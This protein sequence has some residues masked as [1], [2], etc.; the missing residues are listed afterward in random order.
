MNITIIG[1]GNIA[2]ALISCIKRTNIEKIFVL[3]N[4]EYEMNNIMVECSSEFSR[5]TIDI[6]TSFPEKIISK[7]NVILFTT[8]AF[9][10]RDILKKISPYIQ[11]NAL[12][13]AFPGIGGFDE[14]VLSIIKNTNINIFSSQRV[15]YIAR[16]LKKGES[17]KVTKKENI[18]VAIKN[19][20]IEIKYLLE[21]LL[22]MDIYVLDNFLEVNLSNS[23]PILHTARLF[24]LFN[25]KTVY[26]SPILFYEEWDDKSS[27]LLLKMNSEFM[28]IVNKMDLKNIKSL[29]EHYGV[30]SVYTMTEKIKSIEAFRGIYT[31]MKE[32]DGGYLPDINSR[33][34]TE[35]VAVGL[36]YIKEYSKK[37][38]IDTPIIDY[39]YNSL[40]KLVESPSK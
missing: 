14:E 7:S 38:N 15:P 12:I 28:Q 9:T 11:D 39:V 22:D 37:L 27:D 19:N 21:N 25:S 2:H 35:D 26:Q 1:F 30:N 23:N 3:S 17:V 13:G 18:F 4:Q 29:E 8:P 16:I 34:F 36:K 33:Y 5:G 32:L 40:K 20:K 24:S 31:P 6:I 10:R